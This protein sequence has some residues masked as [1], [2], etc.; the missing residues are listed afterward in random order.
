MIVLLTNDD[1]IYAEG[2]QILSNTLL[3]DETVNIYIVA[4]DHERSA[5]GHAITMHRPLRAE[6]VKFYHNVALKGWAVNG[7]PSD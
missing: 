7:T 4:P 3:Q 6:E 5:T 2:I 1:G